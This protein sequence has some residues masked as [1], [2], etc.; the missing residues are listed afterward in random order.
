MKKKKKKQKSCDFFS[1]SIITKYL[2]LFQVADEIKA[3]DNNNS[4]ARYTKKLMME[5]VT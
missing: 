1:N 3:L 2:D 5:E 4:R